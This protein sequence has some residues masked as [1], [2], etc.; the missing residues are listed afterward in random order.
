MTFSVIIPTLNE[1]H[2]IEKL[3]LYLKQF[4]KNEDIEF[5]VCDGGSNDKTCEIALNC[6]A[7][8]YHCKEKSRATQ[9]NFGA[10]MAKG[11]VFY[12]VHADT[13]PPNTF[14]FCISKAIKDGFTS[15]CCP[16]VFD[17]NR[18]IFRFNEWWTGRKNMFV[19]G[20][21]QTLFI[22]KE[23]FEEHGGFDT[24]YV[25]MEDF[26]FTKRLRKTNKFTILKSK[27][28]ISA[29]KYEKNSYVRVNL[30]NA[31]AISMFYLGREPKVIAEFYKKHIRST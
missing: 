29:R 31:W 26:E 8:V 6:G 21:D 25:I 22:T 2:N 13:L 4:S 27:V 7:I 20:G 28:I 3:L 19:G 1:E 23:A 11:E 24:K 9:M 14:I 16:F 17:S 18:L 12:F 30:V 5:L 15:G 10:K